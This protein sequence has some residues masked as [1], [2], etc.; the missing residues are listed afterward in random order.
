MIVPEVG[1]SY[2]RRFGPGQSGSDL[3]LQL[4]A[5]WVAPCGKAACAGLGNEKPA[6]RHRRWRR[7][8]RG[9]GAVVSERW[10]SAGWCDAPARCPAGC[11]QWPV[12]PPAVGGQGNV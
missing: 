11:R 10:P 12:T 3:L 5:V 6:V 7:V 8:R 9:A 1:V 2:W 4:A